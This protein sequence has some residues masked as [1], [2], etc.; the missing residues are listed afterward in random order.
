MRHF[1]GQRLKR[2]DRAAREAVERGE[3]PG[4]VALVSRGD[5]EHVVVAGN[6]AIE[7]PPMQRNSLFRISSM[8]KPVTAVAALILLEECLIRLDE[9][10]DRL[11][12]ELAGRMVLRHPGAAL[13]DVVPATRQITVRDLL[14]FTFGFGMMMD[15]PGPLPVWQE[16]DGLEISNG[17]PGVAACPPSD[18]W[19][20]RFATLPLMAQPG[21]RWLYNTAY[22]VLGVLIERASGQLLGDF[23]RERIF[24]PLG[25][26]DTAFAVPEDRRSRLTTA[27]MPDARSGEM[28]VWDA[29]DGY[30]SNPA[31]HSGAAGLVSTLDDFHAFAR[32]LLNGGEWN[33]QRVISR[34]AVSLMTSDR[35]TA[36]QRASGALE[37]GFFDNHG[38][39][40]GVAV[41]NRRQNLGES[42]GTYYWDGGLGTIWRNDPVEDLVVILLTQ[43]AWS[44]PEPPLLSRDIVT[45]AYQAVR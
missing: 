25:M 31:F 41:V 39:G 19:I 5:E 21:E 45:L 36:A 42:A 37:P 34:S 13:D 8:T 15:A 28:H 35:L 14:T 23:M 44:S 26:V 18:E 30:W 10:V 32:M 1:D 4:L 33:G 11:L 40:Y 12:P 9:P 22:D 43:V 27:Y 7:A 6:L 24:E 3:L 2:I 20:R 16:H 38:W 29:P 17:P